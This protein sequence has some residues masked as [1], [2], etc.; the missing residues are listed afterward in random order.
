MGP[1]FIFVEECA[2]FGAHSGFRRNGLILSHRLAQIY[3]DFAAGDRG[4]LVVFVK[5]VSGYDLLP[6]PA[7]AGIGGMG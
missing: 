7:F 2:K 6:I 1:R 3:S 5:L 4:A